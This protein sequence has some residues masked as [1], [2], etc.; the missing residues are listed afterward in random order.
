MPM[1][2][3]KNELIKQK[4]VVVKQVIFNAILLQV[5]HYNNG[6]AEYKY[7]ITSSLLD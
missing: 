3:K 4:Y 1:E 6:K 7:T 2:K 5:K